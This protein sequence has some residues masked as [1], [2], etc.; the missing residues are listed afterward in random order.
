M[1]SLGAQ[2]FFKSENDV[3]VTTDILFSQDGLNIFL[4][5]ETPNEG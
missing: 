1:E 2:F 5:E 3:E 4:K